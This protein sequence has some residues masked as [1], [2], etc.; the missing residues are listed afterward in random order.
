MAENAN[1]SRPESKV[2]ILPSLSLP[3]TGKS[4]PHLLGSPRGPEEQL[5]VVG[6]GHDDGR[7]GAPVDRADGGA[8]PAAPSNPLVALVHTAVYNGRAIGLVNYT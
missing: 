4:H 5:R 1:P 6:V 2:F 3:H 8:V 7:V